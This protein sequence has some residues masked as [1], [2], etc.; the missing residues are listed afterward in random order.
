[1]SEIIFI[2]SPNNTASNNPY[3]T[4]S[5]AYNTWLL[6]SRG[7]KILHPKTY[8]NHPISEGRNAICREFLE[9]EAT[10]LFMYDAD[11]VLRPNTILVLLEDG[12]EVVSGYYLARKGTG[13]LVVLKRTTVKPLCNIND[14]NYY[15][16]YTLR[17]FFNL[18]REE[19]KLIRVDGTG[20]GAVLIKREVFEE[21][22]EPYFLEWSSHMPPDQHQFGE[23]LWF[24]EALAK[25]GIPIYVDLSQ[26]IG[27]VGWIVLGYEHLKR[28][29]MSEGLIDIQI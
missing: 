20:M 18:P 9:S 27:H 13:A 19:K 2:A 23:D 5:L 8:D 24:S 10:H 16:S 29:M 25:A 28:F 17:E 12:R 26:F 22:E 11:S 7:I 21:L 15:R 3:V 6:G 4:N 1:M 14:F